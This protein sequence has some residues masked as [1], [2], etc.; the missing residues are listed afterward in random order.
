RNFC[1]LAFG[2][3]GLDYREFVREDPQFYRPAEVDLLIG[4]ASRAHQVLGW[5]PTYAFPQLVREMVAN[6]LELQQAEARRASAARH[7]TLA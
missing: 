4:D 6:D 2:E 7:P 5:R 1:E 3:A